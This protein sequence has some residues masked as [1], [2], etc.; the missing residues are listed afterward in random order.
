MNKAAVNQTT[1]KEKAREKKNKAGTGTPPPSSPGTSKG[2]QLRFAKW[3]PPNRCGVSCGATSSTYDIF[4]LDSVGT[5]V[6]VSRKLWKILINV[7]LS[8]GAASVAS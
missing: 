3:Y 4:Y 1:G 5:S 2:A 7:V 6:T 8:N